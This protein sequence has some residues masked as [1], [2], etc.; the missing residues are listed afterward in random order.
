MAGIFAAT[1]Q[2]C[3][4]GSRALIHESIHD[5]FVERLL[6]ARATARMGDPL[7]ATTQ[8][9]PI[10][11][12]PQYQKVL[13]YIDIAKQR[14]R[15]LRARRRPR[16]DP[17]CGRR[18]VRRADGLRRRAPDMR[19]AQE[20]VF[21]PVLS[22]IPFDGEEEALEIANGTIY[23]LAPG[24]WTS[25]SAARTMA[26]ALEAGTVWINTYRVGAHVAVRRLQALRLRP[27]ER[28]PRDP[29]IRAEKSVW[30]EMTE[31]VQDPFV[32]RA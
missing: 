25:T 15:D 5:E 16:D 28:D 17:G 12:Q 20:E 31:E 14:G 27:R 9:G 29:R 13:G 18:L 32:L 23:G 7:E 2:T 24:V 4:A 3:V 1:G 19:I 22:I 26:Q 21:G 30:I 10:T 11:T 8:V 6:E